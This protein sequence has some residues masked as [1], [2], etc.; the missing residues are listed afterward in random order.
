MTTRYEHPLTRFSRRFLSEETG[1]KL[2]TLGRI[3][4]G[5]REATKTEQIAL[6]LVTG[7]DKEILFPVREN[8][9]E[10]S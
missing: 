5:E 8:E 7:L 10:A 2:C 4:R 3:I 6:C 9:K 1:I